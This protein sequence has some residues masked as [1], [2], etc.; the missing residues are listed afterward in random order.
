MVSNS[1]ESSSCTESLNYEIATTIP[2]FEDI[3]V[4]VAQN[5]YVDL[6]FDL[7]DKME[8]PH[9]IKSDDLI[10]GFVAFIKVKDVENSFN[11]KMFDMISKLVSEGSVLFFNCRV[12]NTPL[13]LVLDL[14]RAVNL[15]YE[16]Y[17]LIS[18]VQQ[19]NKENVQKSSKMFPEFSGQDLRLWPNQNEEVFLLKCKCKSYVECGQTKYNLYCLTKIEFKQFLNDFA[20]EIAQ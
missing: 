17:I 13:N 15:K 1:E 20:N 12:S 14:Y 7:M 18:P 16:K 2:T 11:K 19:Q 10:L 9:C 5:S 6:P 3:R 8:E 4:I